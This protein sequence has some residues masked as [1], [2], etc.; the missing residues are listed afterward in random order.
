M[1]AGVVTTCLPPPGDRK[2]F[3]P[4]ISAHCARPLADRC[5]DLVPA[6]QQEP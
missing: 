1:S 4:G 5:R 2:V 6:H 3:P